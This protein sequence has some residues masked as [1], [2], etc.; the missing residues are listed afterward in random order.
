MSP[1]VHD[2]YNRQL[3]NPTQNGQQKSGLSKGLT[4]REQIE[5]EEIDIESTRLNYQTEE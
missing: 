5:S 3:N 4:D 1:F 2:I